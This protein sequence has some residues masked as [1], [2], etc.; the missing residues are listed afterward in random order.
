L[1]EP[2]GSL[3][4]DRVVCPP[5]LPGDCASGITCP[6]LF[7][8][9]VSWAPLSGSETRAWARDWSSRGA[10]RA[11]GVPCAAGVWAVMGRERDAGDSAEGRGT[12]GCAVIVTSGFGSVASRL[13][14]GASSGRG[15]LTVP[16]SGDRFS[17]I[18]VFAPI[19]ELSRDSIFRDWP[20]VGRPCVSPL[21]E[22]APGSAASPVGTASPGD[23]G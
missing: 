15:A 18:T 8:A 12:R 16:R 7:G 6:D 11:S 13:A 3:P 17:S 23:S 21:R 5:G 14:I 1:L 4:A 22:T 20:C 9:S 19:C 2:S 10:T